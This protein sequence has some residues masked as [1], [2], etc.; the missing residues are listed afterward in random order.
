MTLQFEGFLG[1]LL[2]VGSGAQPTGFTCLSPSTLERPSVLSSGCLRSGTL[3]SGL[4]PPSPLTF[5]TRLRFFPS[6]MFHRLK[7]PCH[8]RQFPTIAHRKCSFQTLGGQD[9]LPSLSYLYVVL[10]ITQVEASPRVKQAAL[11][12]PAGM[13]FGFQQYSSIIEGTCRMYISGV[14][15]L[16]QGIE[17]VLVI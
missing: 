3:V 4:L 14:K 7:H 10:K 15:T 16:V 9:V 5:I 12:N 2:R 13:E 17:S 11:Q 1:L 6:E 8:S